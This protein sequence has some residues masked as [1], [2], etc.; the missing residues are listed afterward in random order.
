M[1]LYPYTR[2]V[3]C[4]SSAPLSFILRSVAL[5]TC[6]ILFALSIYAQTTETRGRIVNEQGEGAPNVSITIKGTNRSTTTNSQGEF[7]LTGLDNN[8]TLIISS[9]GYE[10]ME[11]KP[12]GQSALTIRLKTRASEMQEVEVVS[13]GYQDIPKE[14]STGS[15]TKID[16]ATL[17]QQ[18]GTNILDRLIGVT[19]GLLF[20]VNKEDGNPQ[21]KTKISIRGLSTIHGPMDPLIVVDGFI[22][23]GDIENINPNTID[24]VTVLKDAAAASIWGARAGNGVIVISTKRGKFNQKL[25]VDVNANII[26]AEKPD[27]FSLPEIS[28]AD[29]IDLEQFLYNNNYF[30]GALNSIYT[31]VSPAVSIFQ[32]TKNGGLSPSDS[33]SLI[34]ALKKSDIRNDLHKYIYSNAVIQQYSV[35]LRGGSANHSYTLGVGYDRN[36]SDVQSRSDK[37]NIKLE[38][39]F[40]P[41]KN[42][43]ILLGVYYTANKGGLGK[44]GI[45]SLSIGGRRVP[46]LRLAD[47]QGNP[48]SVPTGYRDE[49][50][51]TAGAGKLLDWKYYPLEDYKHNKFKSNTEEIYS[52]VG[53][54]YKINKLFALDLKFQHQKQQIQTE[55]IFDI[56]SYIT[57][58][59]INTYSSINGETG[60]VSYGVPFGAILKNTSSS[61]QS[62]TGRAQL[63]FNH[64]G[65]DH[66]ISAILGSEI[67]QARALG[68]SNTTYGYNADPLLYANVDYVNVYRTYTGGY[69]RIPDAPSLSH[70]L[71]RFV[72][73]FG[74]A[75]YTFKN[76]YSL[77]I[78][79]RKDGSN[80]F[81]ATANDK[82]KPLWSAG[83]AWKISNEPFYKSALFP[84]LRLRTTYGYSGN[85]DLTKTA[86]AVGSYSP[87]SSINLPYVQIVAPQ[88]PSLQWEKIGM[89]NIG[90]E[91]ELKGQTLSGSIEYYRKKGTDLYGRTPYDYT[92]WGGGGGELVRNVANMKGSGLDVILNSK[93][94]NKVFKW[95]SSLL[96]NY[97]SS[98]ISKYLSE[99]AQSITRIL[100]GGTGIS[101]V[102]GKPLYAIAAYQW[103]G[104]D[105]LGN[106]QGF[107]NGELST[108]YNAI[109]TESAKAEEGNLVYIGPSSPS[110]FGSL[111]NSFAFKK[112]SLSINLSY[113]L[114]YYVR[115]PALNYYQL[116][117]QGSGHSDYANRWMKPGDERTT[118]IPSFIYPVNQNRE[119]FYA[120]SEINVLKA[121]HIKIRYINLSYSLNNPASRSSILRHDIQVYANAANLGMLWRA[122]KAGL[123]PE[124]PSSLAPSRKWTIGIRANF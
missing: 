84:V 59:T 48:V 92:V 7:V 96:L 6:G 63:L 53:I 86:V 56:E 74:N 87:S 81:G 33:A 113:N 75:S 83:T 108:N 44:P 51:D 27:F 115:R 122:N 55:Q 124:Y 89:F 12:Q 91:F 90:L 99:S 29:F 111:I 102:V 42:L 104:L 16:N 114:G 24:N 47:N 52:I 69:Q 1:R 66:E 28:S 34:N 10:P 20:D 17:N 105:A 40:Q 82:W 21:N 100:G 41:V 103:G 101:P 61:I 36:L 30:N 58:N 18:T 79:S 3:Y 117:S 13:T 22:Y 121:D 11:F 73:L 8:T 85:V 107:V 112:L 106:P 78:S 23:E 98:K 32:R 46:Y 123:D 67:R 64:S 72:S 5:I 120:L 43:Q 37:L 19:S 62:H 39:I 15:F 54:N 95:N 94:I 45:R 49:Y 35:N 68:N 57:R 2:K 119:S 50:T 9:I 25:K 70:T 26:V 118:T 110:V 14:R 31:A 60:V 93:N 109:Q 88:N 97:N 65:G 4:Q 76:K 77:S 71:N 38:N 116:V 80:L